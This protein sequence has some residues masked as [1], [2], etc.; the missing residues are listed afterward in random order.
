MACYPAVNCCNSQFWPSLLLSLDDL[1]L[2]AQ[3]LHLSVCS[4]APKGKL[5]DP[6]V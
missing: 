1:I 5:Y 3:F 2:A 4:Y 6:E